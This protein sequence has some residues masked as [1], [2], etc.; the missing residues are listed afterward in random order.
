[1]KQKKSNSRFNFEI[2]LTKIPKSKRSQLKIQEMAFMLLA[3]VLFFILVGLFIV[4]VIYSNL[5]KE[6][7]LISESRTLSLV[8][9]LADSPEFSCSTYKSN[10]V[11]SDKLIS[12]VG[13]KTYENF[14]PFSSLKLVKSTGFDKAEEEMLKCTIANYPNCDIFVVYDREVKNE[15]AISSFVALCRKELENEYTYDKCE[16]AKLVAGTE[17]KEQGE[18]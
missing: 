2:K 7:N 11:D 6:A 10:C 8:T 14:W 4:S 9:N 3:V 1:M 5:Y 13:R 17:I 12:L 15:K 16:I 18:R